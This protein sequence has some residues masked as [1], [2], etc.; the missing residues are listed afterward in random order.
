M[1]AVR[2]SLDSAISDLF[3][4]AAIIGVGGLAVV[5]FLREEPLR[6]T[7]LSLEQQEM[8][9]AEAESGARGGLTPEG[10]AAEGGQEPVIS[11]GPEPE[12]EG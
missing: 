7:H 10:N 5:L 12:P 6:K 4:L 3:F 2:H 11:C 1:N 9:F 8:L